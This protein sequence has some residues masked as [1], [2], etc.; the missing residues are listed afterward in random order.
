MMDFFF[1]SITPRICCCCCRATFLFVSD[2][3]IA[4]PLRKALIDSIVILGR[5][6][7][8]DFDISEPEKR[9]KREK[10][11]ER[12]RKRE[13][14]K[15]RERKREIHSRDRGG[16][17][18]DWHMWARARRPWWTGPYALASARGDP[19]INVGEF[20]SCAD[21]ASNS[22]WIADYHRCH[23]PLFYSNFFLFIIFFGGGGGFFFFLYFFLFFFIVIIIPP[24]LLFLL[25]LVRGQSW[26]II[27]QKKNEKSNRF[28]EKFIPTC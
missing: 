19:R 16:W 13:K 1:Y 9:R 23:Q 15:E 26:S 21:P 18:Q 17:K 27:Q 2:Q 5:F 28:S 24:P 7:R 10:E 6:N 25:F 12:E 8:V 4:P 20:I 3:L 14:E 22:R 11:R